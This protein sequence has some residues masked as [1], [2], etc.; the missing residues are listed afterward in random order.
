MS[1]VPA[2]EQMNNTNQPKFAKDADHP[3]P[4]PPGSL[5]K[6]NPPLNTE[7]LA[8]K[9]DV[10][11]LLTD[12]DRQTIPYLVKARRAANYLA[13]AMIYLKDNVDIRQPLKQEH[14]KDR[15]LGHW[16]TW[17]CFQIAF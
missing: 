14:V 17:W 15:L 1:P 9:L 8:I 11:S 5:I 3:G 4:Q 12:E 10:Q 7:Q 2:A 16:G 13:V 6:V